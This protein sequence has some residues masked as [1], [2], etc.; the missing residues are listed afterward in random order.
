MQRIHVDHRSHSKRLISTFFRLV[1]ALQPL[2]H[3]TFAEHAGDLVPAL[4]VEGHVLDA[5]AVVVVV[6]VTGAAPGAPDGA[7]QPL[8]VGQLGLRGVPVGREDKDL[9][10]DALL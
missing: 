4:V 8:V 1:H 5:A 2:S 9:Y 3:L 7:V 6:V 10:S